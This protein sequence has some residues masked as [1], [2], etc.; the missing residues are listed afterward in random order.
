MQGVMSHREGK[1]LTPLSSWRLRWSD[2]ARLVR[3][4]TTDAPTHLC[5]Q[6]LEAFNGMVFTLIGCANAFVPPPGL[7]PTMHSKCCRSETGI[8]FP[9]VP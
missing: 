6:M 5:G 3:Q 1:G 7:Q 8:R 9:C 2:Q 4:R